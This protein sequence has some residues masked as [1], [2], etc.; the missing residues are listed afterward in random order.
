MVLRF[1][2]GKKTGTT[3]ALLTSHAPAEPETGFADYRIKD[4]FGS[5]L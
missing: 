3:H 4:L 5:A 1:V 2:P